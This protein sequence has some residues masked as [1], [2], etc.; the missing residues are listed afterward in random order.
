MYGTGEATRKE[1]AGK[2]SGRRRLAV[3]LAVDQ[4]VDGQ[5]HIAGGTVSNVPGVGAESG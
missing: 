4:S 1:M 5:F 2:S 3:S